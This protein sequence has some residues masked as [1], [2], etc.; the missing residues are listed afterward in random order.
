MDRAALPE[1]ELLAS[2]HYEAPVGDGEQR[3]AALW[4]EVLG[5][6]RVGRQDHFLSWAGTRCWP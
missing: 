4:S 6:E 5:V 3:L 2:L 1:P